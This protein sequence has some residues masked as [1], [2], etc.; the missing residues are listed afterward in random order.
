MIWRKFMVLLYLILVLLNAYYANFLKVYFFLNLKFH[1]EN[2]WYINLLLICIIECIY[3]SSCSF[4][5]FINSFLKLEISSWKR[6]VYR[7]FIILYFLLILLSMYYNDPFKKFI[8]YFSKLEI[9]SWN[10]ISCFYHWAYITKAFLKS[11]WILF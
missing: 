5:K 6:T 8:D 11:A 10:F 9:S 7:N 4:E 3:N 2:E 1:H